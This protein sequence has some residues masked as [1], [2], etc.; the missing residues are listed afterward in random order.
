MRIR[1]LWGSTLPKSAV[2]GPDPI[3]LRTLVGDVRVQRETYAL[4]GS[5]GLV[6]LDTF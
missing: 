2:G 6:P 1:F 3:P 5:A 4:A